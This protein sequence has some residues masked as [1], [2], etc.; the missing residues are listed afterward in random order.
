MAYRVVDGDTF[1]D[2]QSGERFRLAGANTAEKSTPEGLATMFD[3]TL[4]ERINQSSVE[5]LGQDYYGRTVARFRNPDNTDINQQLINE[6]KAG[7][8]DY[9]GAGQ[10]Y[11]EPTFARDPYT[12]EDKALAGYTPTPIGY[13]GSPEPV[14]PTG[15][16]KFGRS[17]ARGVDTNQAGFYGTMS[18]VGNLIARDPDGAGP[19]TDT[20][21]VTD[22][23]QLSLRD[24]FSNWLQRTGERGY[25]RN[26]QE[27]EQNPKTASFKG[28][29][30]G[31]NDLTSLVAESLG[32]AL[33]S[34]A[35]MIGTGAATAATGGAVGAIAGGAAA[36]GALGAGAK[37][38]A[39]RLTEQA[40]VNGIRK[41]I[42][43]GELS[44]AMKGMS[45]VEAQKLAKGV[46]AGLPEHA[47]KFAGNQEALGTIASLAGRGTSEVA[48]RA[49]FTTGL[50]AGMFGSS[51]GMQAGQF[52]EED[53][54]EAGGVASPG[55][56]LLA[57]A[58][59][60]ALD[61][62]GFEMLVHRFLSPKIDVKT[63]F[64][65]VKHVAAQGALGMT[66][67]GATEAVQEVIGVLN[68]EWDN[69]SDVPLLDRMTS[70]ENLWRYAE[71]G[72]AGALFG[73][74]F[75]GIGGTT[76]G[77]SARLS[78]PGAAPPPTG[79]QQQDTTSSGEQQQETPLVLET[80]PVTE[81]L[82]P[83]G[84]PLPTA[85]STE[86]GTPPVVDPPPVSA[87]ASPES[88]AQSEPSELAEAPPLPAP[89]APGASSSTSPSPA[90]P[91]GSPGSASSPRPSSAPIVLGREDITLT[92]SG[93]RTE[94]PPADPAKLGALMG[95]RKPKAP[96][97]EAPTQQNPIDTALD[98]FASKHGPKTSNPDAAEKYRNNYLNTLKENFEK[99]K[100]T[101][102]VTGWSSK[103]PDGSYSLDEKSQDRFNILKALA[104]NDGYDLGEPIIR[105]K[106]G[107]YTA[108]L[109]PKTATPITTTTT[110]SA[111]A[112]AATSP[113]TSPAPKGAP[114]TT[115]AKG[116]KLPPGAKVPP[117]PAATPPGTPPA[118]P[119]AS[120][121]VAPPAPTQSAASAP[122]AL[123]APAQSVTAPAPP[124]QTPTLSGRESRSTSPAPV[125][126]AQS[127][128]VSE[129]P[130][131]I[132][133]RDPHDP[134]L[135]G[136]IFWNDSDAD[137]YRESLK[138]VGV[139]T[140]GK[141]EDDTHAF[142]LRST[143][144]EV[145]GDE[146]ASA[147]GGT[148]GY[149][150]LHAHQKALDAV[151]GDL[152]AMTSAFQANP[153]G[154]A[155]TY[156]KAY[157]AALSA[158]LKPGEF[159]VGKTAEG[160]AYAPLAAKVEAAPVVKLGS[161]GIPVAEQKQAFETL[162][163]E[164]RKNPRKLPD[165]IIAKDAAKADAM[166]QFIGEGRS[167]KKG[168]S[169]NNYAQWAGDK[170][171]T[172]EYSDRDKVFVS[173]NGRGEGR[174]PLMKD[175]K[176][177][178]AFQ[179]LEKA[180][181]ARATILADNKANRSRDHN[182]GERDLADYLTSKGYTESVGKQFSTW[183][184]PAAK[185]SVK[186]TSAPNA[187]ERLEARKAEIEAEEAADAAETKR[188]AGLISQIRTLTKGDD[189]ELAGVG[190][191]FISTQDAA[192]FFAQH[193][194]D[195]LPL[196]RK[197]ARV[198]DSKFE[199]ER[200]KELRLNGQNIADWLE[201][202]FYGE[203]GPPQEQQPNQNQTSL[204]S[205]RQTTG[206]GITP[207]AFKR[208]IG[209]TNLAG[210]SNIHVLERTTDAPFKVAADTAGL[211]MPNGDLYFF[212]ENIAPGE[213]W[214]KFFHEVGAHYGLPRMLGRDAYAAI[215]RDLKGMVR[216]AASKPLMEAYRKAKQA[217]ATGADLYHETIGYLGEI[218]P[219]HSIVQRVIT[220]VRQFLRSLGI[221]KGYTEQDIVGLIQSAAMKRGLEGK[222]GL[223][224][225]AF[226]SAKPPPL[227]G[228]LQNAKYMGI[229]EN[230]DKW[231]GTQY[232][233]DTDSLEYYPDT[234]GVKKPNNLPRMA[235]QDQIK[236]LSGTSTSPPPNRLQLTAED[237]VTAQ[238]VLPVGALKLTP[239]EELTNPALNTIAKELRTT[240]D[241]AERSLAWMQKP[242]FL[243][244]AQLLA[245][246]GRILSKP[247]PAERIIGQL[248]AL[249]QSN[250]AQSDQL[251]A[252]TAFVSDK[253]LPLHEH[254]LR[255]L[256]AFGALRKRKSSTI[257]DIPS[258]MAPDPTVDEAF[259]AF[260]ASLAASDKAG[261]D[262][263]AQS[264]YQREMLILTSLYPVKSLGK[265]I[266]PITNRNA[267]AG[268]QIEK[269][270]E[271]FKARKDLTPLDRTLLD[272][273]DKAAASPKQQAEILL[274][275]VHSSD[276]GW[277]L[278]TFGKSLMAAI[279]S[280]KT[281]VPEGMFL[282]KL[283]LQRDWH[284][285]T[286]APYGQLVLKYDAQRKGNDQERGH[287]AVTERI[288]TFDPDTLMLVEN[289]TTKEYVTVKE[290]V[291]NYVAEK[292]SGWDDRADVGKTK[293]FWKNNVLAFYA[294][295]KITDT[296]VEKA[297]QGEKLP[298][299]V[300]ATPVVYL[301]A[302][303]VVEIG[304]MVARSVGAERLPLLRAYEQGLQTLQTQ[305]GRSYVLTPEYADEIVMTP[306]REIVTRRSEEGIT[307][308]PGKILDPPKFRKERR[309]PEATQQKVLA[310]PNY[311]PE[312]DTETN[313]GI[314]I[315]QLK[316]MSEAERNALNQDQMR[317]R[318]RQNK[319]DRL[320]GE[321]TNTSN[322]IDRKTDPF[323]DADTLE[324]QAG[325]QAAQ[326]R[327]GKT[328][329]AATSSRITARP[330]AEVANSRLAPGGQAELSLGSPDRLENLA[331][332]H[333]PGVSRHE[334]TEAHGLVAKIVK[335]L[336][337]TGVHIKLYNNDDVASMLDAL[338]PFTETR[339]R[340]STAL[341]RATPA[342]A[343][344]AFIDGRILLYV[345]KN[346]KGR[347]L[348]FAVGHEM[349]H[350][351]LRTV[352]TNERRKSS[353]L[354]RRLLKAYQDAMYKEPTGNGALEYRDDVE[355]AS[356]M[357]WFA[358]QAADWSLQDRSPKNLIEVIYQKVQ[359]LI[360][361]LLVTL[362]VEPTANAVHAYLDGLALKER[363]LDFQALADAMRGE[364]NYDLLTLQQTYYGADITQRLVL[365]SPE[366][367][368][369]S[370]TG[371]AKKRMEQ[372][373]SWLAAR[374]ALDKRVKAF[375]K[376]VGG[377]ATWAHDVFS[378]SGGWLRSLGH[379]AA[380][381][382]A[383]LLAH[384]ARVGT[385]GVHKNKAELIA[386]M[387]AL[388]TPIT[389]AER[390]TLLDR[391]TKI[392]RNK[393]R[394]GL[395]GLGL[396][397][398]ASEG[399]IIKTEVHPIYNESFEA[400]VRREDRGHWGASDE[401]YYKF[402]HKGTTEAEYEAIGTE[403]LRNDPKSER[404]EV[405]DTWL[406]GF[407]D[408]YI[409]PGFTG[410]YSQE[411][412]IGRHKDWGMARFYSPDKIQEN[413]DAFKTLLMTPDP[414][415][416]WSGMDEVNAEHLIYR[417]ING[418][419]IAD[420]EGDHLMSPGAASKKTR[421]I[422]L[423]I[424]K[425]LPYL[426]TNIAKTLP[427]YVHSMVRRVE[428][429]RRFSDEVEIKI[430][431][432]TRWIWQRN[433]TWDLLRNAAA[434]GTETDVGRRAYLRKH[435]NSIGEAAMGR[436]GAHQV[437]QR[438]RAGMS[439]I[440][441]ATNFL[442]MPL[443]LLS[444]GTD[445]AG[446][447]I[448]SGGD[449]G[450]A[451]KGLREA[452]R[453]VRDSGG[454]A[455][456]MAEMAG[457]IF[458]DTR[459]TFAASYL[460]SPYLTE[461]AQKWNDG[462][463]KWNG[464]QFFT[465]FSRLAS[466]HAS[467]HWLR[468]LENHPDAERLL[469]QVDLTTDDLKE[470]KKLGYRDYKTSDGKDSVPFRIML[471][472]SRFVQESNFAPGSS[473]RP[474]WANHPYAM[475]VWHLKQFTYSY[476]TQMIKPVMR[477][478]FNNPRWA[479]KAAATLPMLVLIPLAMAG[480]ALR[481]ELKYGLGR[482]ARSPTDDDDWLETTGKVLG[483]TGIM[484]PLQL[485]M[486]A[487]NAQS[488]GR[489]FAFALTSPSISKVEE[490]FRAGSFSPL[491][492]GLSTLPAERIAV[493][494]WF[495]QD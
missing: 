135:K 166:T 343:A 205:T 487:D 272:L 105:G 198:A 247:G 191:E 424:D 227:E 442:V 152:K 17:I 456:K 312:G 36:R 160:F 197:A 118:P 355:P 423:P 287:Y 123:H 363:Q 431:G 479:G 181:A 81:E 111:P 14:K 404:A 61:L 309:P 255:A 189:A 438:T 250:P 222:P 220:A 23:K 97:V 94:A 133:E 208:V 482:D 254:M 471:A 300:K 495:A 342:K 185:P 3:P 356:F 137:P 9:T 93:R 102:A 122:V 100:Q 248:E 463:F 11:N 266:S 25:M 371:W 240:P 462:L 78:Q 310:G 448:R 436:Y 57:G 261:T 316:A 490:A 210:R 334:G 125:G 405:I 60:G 473:Q 282:R 224:K 117:A 360:D 437:D 378:T 99:E 144:S 176:L 73:G 330:W 213:E 212:T 69:P 204:F 199:S 369:M 150:Q 216:M 202:G 217:G 106:S 180:T 347:D 38:Y 476:F 416:G 229:L 253:T 488:W 481:D 231:L 138:A 403:L 393:R 298:P 283:Q 426:E 284:T 494:R 235:R 246:Y 302:K 337:L 443:S 201:Y 145:A 257:D 54:N 407:F 333:Q 4:K 406:K 172:G 244:I 184:P 128:L 90:S 251:R 245:N 225:S 76:S 70:K 101:G 242:Q 429:D 12:A 223:S 109:S 289:P 119:A 368:F 6:G 206:S 237:P 491:T 219:K 274:G 188:V 323:D 56:S 439:W 21:T 466:F 365:D 428:W 412:H 335:N 332:Q 167:N 269:D 55:R 209:K 440:Q 382:L 362:G 297:P 30:E 408:N 207:E 98:I 84:S 22:N 328:S 357:E 77:I 33:P 455:Y 124:S 179:N 276:T 262:L 2:E 399:D 65:V 446:P 414:T 296:P 200:I 480:M 8:V 182:V 126:K 475:L 370:P 340:F 280:N 20:R 359:V 451:A 151:G 469:K 148:L 281:G 112:P 86:V 411:V 358:D 169:T 392:Y 306:V 308:E 398:A 187:R 108:R 214:G 157:N 95:E 168:S 389:A 82:P 165:T 319:A 230:L 317:A 311:I 136:E 13:T 62:V 110:E 486:D 467:A 142:A 315:G 464:M 52:Y 346:L 50:R 66:G 395:L 85:S 64:D 444:Q 260:T 457:V 43:S 348:A 41:R 401:G 447:F 433:Q 120:A 183:T 400:A 221:V 441:T 313:P 299:G 396:S 489:S 143:E 114:A 350:V 336:N 243:G 196:Y 419:D 177:N 53:K 239:V 292:S 459:N 58:A 305:A 422:P 409:V 329:D 44:A 474:V 92:P 89:P 186:Q 375:T 435:I 211:A 290:W 46:V 129:P 352:L 304:Q 29:L 178:G 394:D 327:I 345:D 483:R 252:L 131:A 32:E 367:D 42:V 354:Y 37:A 361:K 193:K 454:E 434:Y 430:P 19:Q 377:V 194:A 190:K 149:A 460:D 147:Q 318:E 154:Y 383:D 384:G 341:T 88:L 59:A 420:V 83:T 238:R 492:P 195:L 307:G 71:A 259:D 107:T 413:K 113:G 277:S 173:V 465:N 26:T 338:M 175:G 16:Q 449:L 458:R 265:V 288:T 163:G 415:V 27:A 146:E 24:R 351:V 67:E 91:T 18:A 72:V 295:D 390:Q 293:A 155:T 35:M 373:Q 303:D 161:T 477:E 452:I 385:E 278:N 484:G 372:V 417:I 339:T 286:G 39:T 381:M 410:A 427:K 376:P 7:A 233:E 215:M 140:A 171:N 1:V 192:D 116:W 321:R 241:A 47:M 271:S 386:A 130:E 258:K 232:R 10:M 364:A 320:A 432:G 285:A 96:P 263:N 450:V 461:G 445:M 28:Y 391:A 349:G 314:T 40:L 127:T 170:A 249:Y 256:D 49:G 103:N 45:H 203:E 156:D 388:E 453:T 15:F 470:W 159:V 379:P 326:S 397:Q 226:K 267:T 366:I 164:I 291:E 387:D 324:K 74:V 228:K 141:L 51:A 301:K 294:L 353:V 236:Q 478:L 158:K 380:T 275:E 31:K 48:G 268:K 322:E 75:G 63:A 344:V 87:P 115:A 132:A 174:V 331:L 264:I 485:L 374:P 162:A 234:E 34:L 80:A 134:K 121:P 153:K 418:E 139:A 472:R 5:R 273:Q 79:E 421:A 279:D 218:S 270:E 325:I 68:N 468:S 104:E 402:W 425:L 493:T